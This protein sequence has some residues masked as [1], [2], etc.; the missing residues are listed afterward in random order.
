PLT[1]A[2]AR[3][4][5]STMAITE[6]PTGRSAE[7][8]KMTGAPPPYSAAP[9]ADYSRC[10]PESKPERGGKRGA[11]SACGCGMRPRC[12]GAREQSLLD[13]AA[14]DVSGGDV[15][16]LNERGGFGRRQQAQIALCRHVSAGLAGEADCRDP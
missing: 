2:W 16:L 7:E 3:R 11:A 5:K 12:V 1:R 9:S 10:E 8:R 6:L 14:D 4:T 13:K 15:D